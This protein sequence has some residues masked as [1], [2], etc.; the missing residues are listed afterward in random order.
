MMSSQFLGLLLVL[1]I[2]C[3]QSSGQMQLDP[4]S[5]CQDPGAHHEHRFSC[6]NGVPYLLGHTV[7]Y[8]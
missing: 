1:S 6:C 4:V 3:K 7:E 5:Y 2:I 8:L